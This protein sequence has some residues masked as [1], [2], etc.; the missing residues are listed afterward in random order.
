[1]RSQCR[2]SHLRISAR[3]CVSEAAYSGALRS[4]PLSLNT[5]GKIKTTVM[6]IIA[7]S[8]HPLSS[9]VRRLSYA[10]APSATPCGGHRYAAHRR[11]R[12]PTM[13]KGVQRPTERV[14]WSSHSSSLC[15]M[16]SVLCLCMMGTSAVDVDSVRPARGE[17]APYLSSI[18]AV[19]SPLPGSFGRSP[20]KAPLPMMPNARSARSKAAGAGGA[21]LMVVICGVGECKASRVVLGVRAG[22]AKL[23]LGGTVM[24]KAVIRIE[25][26]L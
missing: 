12:A 8:P 11:Q 26:R 2:R 10:D 9:S 18:Y 7:S 20:K 15:R 16:L 14:N 25:Q 22:K 4:S 5:V 23:W 19:K 1:M 17:R 13:P 24:T 6:G 3:T 21:S